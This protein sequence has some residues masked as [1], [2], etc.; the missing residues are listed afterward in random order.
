VERV[1]TGTWR[2]TFIN[3]MPNVNYAI[4]GNIE[5]S[6]VAGESFHTYW[7]RQNNEEKTATTFIFHAAFSNGSYYDLQGYAHFVVY[8]A[9]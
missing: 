8:G 4:I 7:A 1:S 2:I 9:P 3:A 6:D 5:E